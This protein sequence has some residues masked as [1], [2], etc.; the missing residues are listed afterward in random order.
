M[1]LPILYTIVFLGH[2]KIYSLEISFLFSFTF[3]KFNIFSVYKARLETTANTV[4]GI[5]TLQ[6]S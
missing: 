6:R 3:F 5:I 4:A 2:G 1:F